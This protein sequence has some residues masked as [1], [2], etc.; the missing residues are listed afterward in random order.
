MKTKTIFDA[1]VKTVSVLQGDSLPT[2][3]AARAALTELNRFVS[4]P[5]LEIAEWDP[6]KGRHEPLHAES[7]P[8]RLLEALNGEVFLEDLCWPVLHQDK[9]PKGWA[10]TDHAVDRRDSSLYQQFIVPL[11]YR[12]GIYLPLFH[13]D[14]YV[15]MVTGNTDAPRPPG[16]EEKEALSALAPVLGEFLYRTRA[17]RT[18]GDADGGILLDTRLEILSFEPEKSRPITEAICAVIRQTWPA[19]G[20]VNRFALW[21]E[22]ARLPL[23]VRVDRAR[24]T[25]GG[26]YVSWRQTPLP[27]GLSRR[28]AEVVTGIVEGLNNND[29]GARLF[30]SPRTVSKHIEHILLKLGVANR[31]AITRQAMIEGIYLLDHRLLGRDD[32][33]AALHS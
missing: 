33:A 11:G 24:H 30:T 26:F 8:P 22:D 25:D 10:D 31:S 19:R 15:G 7:F 21:P 17:R 14:R 16:G 18:T 2:S 5:S 27:S 29:I 20:P 28:Q 6:E 13:H 4:Y 1:T 9:R 32:I 12:E 23:R 3:Y